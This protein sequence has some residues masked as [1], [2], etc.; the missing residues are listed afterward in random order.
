M[1]HGSLTW[2]K[3]S[4]S[5]EQYNCV[6]MARL[7]STTM[8]IRDSKAPNEPVLTLDRDDWSSLRTALGLGS[9]A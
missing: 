2:R 8:A 7:T 6:E 9:T 4:H 3:S 1:S 5:G